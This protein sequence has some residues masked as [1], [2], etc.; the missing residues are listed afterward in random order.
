MTATFKIHAAAKGGALLAANPNIG[1]SKAKSDKLSL[2][3]PSLTPTAAAK[4]GALLAANPNI[5]PG[6]VSDKLSLTFPGLT[7]TAARALSSRWQRIAR[8]WIET[9]HRCHTPHWYADNEGTPGS[10]HLPDGSTARRG[11]P[12][13]PCNVSTLC[14]PPRRHLH[15][16][17]PSPLPCPLWARPTLS[18]STPHE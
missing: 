4:G 13:L 5:G 2:L 14:T 15:S 1:S 17:T 18:R 3:F 11:S 7:S 9:V 16:E 12:H 6:K 8:L 10:T